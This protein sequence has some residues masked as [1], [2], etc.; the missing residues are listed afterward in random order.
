VG[1]LRLIHLAAAE[2]RLNVVVADARRGVQRAVDVVLGD[3][4]DQWLAVR[5]CR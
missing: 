2:L 3:A 5:A 1:E 4:C